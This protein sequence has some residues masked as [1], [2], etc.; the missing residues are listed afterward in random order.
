[1]VQQCIYQNTLNRDGY[2]QVN[3]YNE[4][5]HN[6]SLQYQVDMFQYYNIL[7]VKNIAKFHKKF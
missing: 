3:D 6:L 1:M 5:I 4:M 2:G 7:H